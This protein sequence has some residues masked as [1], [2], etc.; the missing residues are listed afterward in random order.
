MI[1]LIYPDNQPSRR[2]AEKNGIKFEKLFKTFPTLVFAIT[3]P[4]WEALP[5]AA[6]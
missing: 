2:V 3:R 6:A 4:G 1:S 5:R